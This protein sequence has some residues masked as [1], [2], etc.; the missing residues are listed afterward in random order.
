MRVYPDADGNLTLSE[1]D[2]GQDSRGVWCVRPPGQHAGGIPNHD[3]TEHDD[4]TIT[5]Y[6]SIVLYET[7]GGIAWHGYL[8]GGEWKSI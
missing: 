3:V 4:G 2:Y 7:D 8:T 6:P 5:V 1:G